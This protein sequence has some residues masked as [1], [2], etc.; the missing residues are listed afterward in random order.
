MEIS[1]LI[2]YDKD[3]RRSEHY[4]NETI[5]TAVNENIRLDI[6]SE[7]YLTCYLPENKEDLSIMDASDWTKYSGDKLTYKFWSQGY[8]D[9]D[10]TEL[11][12]NDMFCDSNW[13][14]WTLTNLE[15]GEVEDSDDVLDSYEECLLILNDFI[16]GDI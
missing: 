15:T 2:P 5:I 16:K 4:Y 10:L 7:G 12:I 1:I 3:K 11:G 14:S 13:F 8:T 9:D 6:F